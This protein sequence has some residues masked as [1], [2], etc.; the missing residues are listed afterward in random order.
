MMACCGLCY[1]KFRDAD[2]AFNEELF[3]AAVKEYRLV[4]A[5]MQNLKKRERLKLLA[6]DTS[7]LRQIAQR[8][9]CPCH[10]V[11]TQILH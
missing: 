4:A 7:Q 2:G 11:G 1:S 6:E 9:G 10:R 3:Q 5:G 8:C